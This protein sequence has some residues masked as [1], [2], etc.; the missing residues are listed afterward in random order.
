[1]EDYVERAIDIGLREI[2]FSDH[3]PLPS[4]YGANV[5]MAERELD[6]YV[7]RVLDLRFQYRGKIE[8]RLGL[9]MDFVESLEDYLAKQISR[10]PFDYILG[11]VHYLDPQ[12]Q[13]GAWSRECPFPVDDHYA[14]YFTGVRKLAQ[15]GLCDIIAHF[16]VVKRA[17]RQPSA[18][19]LAEIPVTLAAIAKAGVCLEINTSGYRHSELTELQPYP[20]LPTVTEALRLGIPL[21][22]NSDAHK[23]EQVGFKFAEVENFLRHHDCRQLAQ[24]ERRQRN[25]YAL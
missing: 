14:S 18:R 25:F 6:Y 12:C 13:L 15:S 17:G 23:P 4:G 9:E 24:F 7:Q 1:M 21:V 19:G 5:R 11:A 10:Y 3:N 16:D 22:V 8:I 20:N 2:G